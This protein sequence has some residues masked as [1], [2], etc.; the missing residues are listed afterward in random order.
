MA[1]AERGGERVSAKTNA[2][3]VSRLRRIASTAARGA[4][5]QDFSPAAMDVIET[6]PSPIRT[7]IMLT[8]CAL[9]ATAIVA[10]MLLEVDIHAV[11]PGRVEAVGRSKIIQ[12]LDDGKVNAIFVS[13]G[14][15]VAKGAQLI[16]LDSTEVLAGKRENEQQYAEQRAEIARR[17]AAIDAAETLTSHH[18]PRI[19]FPVDIDSDIQE[20]ERA[21]L[22]TDLRQLRASVDSLDAKLAES[23]T[24]AK[25][26]ESTIVV[27]KEL[28]ETL[29]QRLSMRESL[30]AQHWET[31]ANVLDAAETL[32]REK[33]SLTDHAG[34]LQQ[35]LA[36]AK[37]AAAQ[38]AETIAKFISDNGQAI[39]A[40]AAKRDNS[41][42]ELVK[43][44]E[45]AAH[46]VVVAP[47]DGTVQ[48]LT[49]TTIGQVLNH[50]QQLMTVVPDAQPI[51]VEALVSNTDIGFVG[52][53]QPAVIKVDTFPFSIYGTV[54]GKVSHVSKD[55]VYAGN[56]RQALPTASQAAQ[57]EGAEGLDNSSVPGTRDLV[58]PVTITLDQT[59]MEVR[60][61]DVALSPGMTVSADILTGRRRIIDYLLAPLREISSN[62]IHER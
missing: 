37:S 62:A 7:T 47:V 10:A 17:Q 22:D 24:Q 61:K 55:A 52:E 9:F 12:P 23:L 16:L 19:N 43:S 33:T 26:L 11:G 34:Q 2:G 60:G 1:A 41:R 44:V 30:E 5:A 48:E 45:K 8:I 35:A 54:S 31:Q 56:I 4:G 20:R 28:I 27:Q 51:E 57:P 36:A 18:S 38:K 6:P 29:R 42:E 58:F 50:G 46:T 14:S 40:A 39:E 49:V 21:V 13:N 59:K 25:A 32:N 3:G 53:G 15:H